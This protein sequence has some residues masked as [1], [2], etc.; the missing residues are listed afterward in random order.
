MCPPRVTFLKLP[1]TSKIK[2]EMIFGRVYQV[3]PSTDHARARMCVRHV[4]HRRRTPVADCCLAQPRLPAHACMRAHRSCA[5]RGVPA[6]VCAAQSGSH[7][8]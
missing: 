4:T 8:E 2:E 3:R 6:G 1:A 7:A 5:Q